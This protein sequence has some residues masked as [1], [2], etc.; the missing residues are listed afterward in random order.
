M[1]ALEVLRYYD[2]RGTAEKM[3]AELKNGYG[4]DKLPCATL[5]A[6]AA[7]FQTALLAYN[8]V[9]AFK[10]SARPEAWR[11]FCVK[12]LLEPGVGALHDPAAWLEGQKFGHAL[13]GGNLLL[14]GFLVDECNKN[15]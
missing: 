2:Q 14:G 15:G 5:A 12:N 3:I 1:R 8:L 11:R 7:L 9:Q 10:R 13:P 6:N 4:L